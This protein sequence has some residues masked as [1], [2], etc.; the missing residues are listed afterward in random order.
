MDDYPQTIPLIYHFGHK[1]PNDN[2]VLYNELVSAL[3]Q[4]IN[5]RCET[6]ETGE[7]AIVNFCDEHYAIV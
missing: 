3:S 6:N 4:T 2:I 5:Q 1:T 7:S